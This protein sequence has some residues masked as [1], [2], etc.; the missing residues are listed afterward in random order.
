MLVLFLVKG[1]ANSPDIIS[2]YLKQIATEMV[3]VQY[4]IDVCTI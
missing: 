2:L 3:L 1:M 4:C